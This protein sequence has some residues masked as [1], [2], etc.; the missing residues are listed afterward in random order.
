VLLARA[1]R[2]DPDIL[3]CARPICER[4]SE[5][6]RETV[7]I[8][9]LEGD[10]AVVI[11]QSISRASAL[12]VDWTGR[13]TPLHATAAGKI[14]LAYMPEDQLLRILEGSLERFTKNTLVD[15]ANLKDHMGKIRDE[16]YGYTFE[17]LETGLNAIG[18]PIRSADGAVV[19][20]VSVSG[21]AFRL[22]PD[23]LP[24][25][26]ELS[27]RAAAKISRCLGFPG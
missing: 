8:A 19:G 18:A 7:T 13:H 9:V 2:A 15:P 10:D 3:R 26:G 12:G 11:H 17:E 23:A 25:I 6:T 24:R 21:P 4:L 1:V 22:R 20:A 27:R 16:G 5:R 14:F